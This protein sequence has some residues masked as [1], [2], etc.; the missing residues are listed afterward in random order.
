M[1]YLKNN[2]LDDFTYNKALQKIIESKRVK[3]EEKEI[4]K[5]MKRG[6]KNE[7]RNSK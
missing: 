5:K 1:E 3:N 7:N 2:K 6:D 4:I